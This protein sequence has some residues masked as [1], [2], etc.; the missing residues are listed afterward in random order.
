[1]NRSITCDVSQWAGQPGPFTLRLVADDRQPFSVQTLVNEVDSNRLRQDLRFVEG[2][3]HRSAGALHLAAVRDSM[4]RLFES[5][6]LYT[7]EQTFSYTGGYTGRNVIGSLPGTTAAEQVVIADAHYDSVNN[8]P[9]ADDNGSGTVG[10]LEL[11]RLLSRYPAKKTLR[12]IGFD[13]EEAGLVGSTRYV[14]A[15]IPAGESIAGVFNFE[16]IGYHS[17]QP[18]SQKLP[19]GFEVLF[20]AAYNAVAGDSFRGN[21]IT[22]VGN[23][24]SKPLISLFAN[25]AAQYVPGLRVVSVEVPGNGQI[26]PDLRRSDHAPF[27]DSGRQALMLSDGA[28]FRNLCYHMGCDTA[29]DK[30]NFS[31]MARVVQATLASMAQLAEIQHGDWATATF[32]GTVGT[33]SAHDRPC[34]VLVGSRPEERN[35]L[36]LKAEDCM[37]DRLSLAL[38]DERGVLLHE[39]AI[40]LLQQGAALPIPLPQALPVG[41]YFARFSWQEGSWTERVLIR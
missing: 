34:R 27:W 13:L 14:N 5:A 4:R 19:A 32:D 31:F 1:T 2:V 11:A 28:N 15:G 40:N 37:L 10:V 7:R 30:L 23:T 38:F 3:R 26:A 21:F 12:F 6:G 36:Y 29:E 39:Q 17:E 35:V 8:A 25:S 24:A 20:P 41:L 16:M 33:Q 18:N 9:G 22:N